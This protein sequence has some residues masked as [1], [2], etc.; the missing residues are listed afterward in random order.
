MHCDSGYR[1]LLVSN[2]QVEGLVSWWGNAFCNVFF[3]GGKKRC[4]ERGP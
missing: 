2:Y 4:T 3:Y 1:H